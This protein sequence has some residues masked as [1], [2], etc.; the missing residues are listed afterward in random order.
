M[1]GPSKT[2]MALALLAALV[3]PSGALALEKVQGGVEE[4][5]SE[6]LIPLSEVDKTKLNKGQVVLG[7]QA[8]PNGRRWVTAKIKIDAHPSLVWDAVHEERKTDPDLA[9]SKVVEENN[10]EKT[11]EQ[12][13]QL[14][15]V[16]GTSVCLIKSTE[17]PHKRIDYYLLKSD[18]FKAVEGS[19]ILQAMEDGSTVLE[20]GS[21][22]DI[23]MPAPRS[24]VEGVASKKL[25]RRLGHVRK[26]AEAKAKAIAQKSSSQ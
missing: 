5:K 23:G 15:P 25:E 17:I 6:V 24:I 4:Q 20:L 9:Y 1:I 26:F 21:Y 10:N 7:T 19:W 13:F 12:K 16:I 18:R 8:R 2:A 11:L 3:L 22:I 14:L